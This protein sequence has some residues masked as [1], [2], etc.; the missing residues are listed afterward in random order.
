[1]KI[2]INN[3]EVEIKAKY[4]FESR[5]NKAATLAMLNQISI[6]YSEAAK[7]FEQNGAAALSKEYNETS[8]IIFDACSENGFYNR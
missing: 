8:D 3:M 2:Y 6:A 4:V 7:M 1:M 5:Y